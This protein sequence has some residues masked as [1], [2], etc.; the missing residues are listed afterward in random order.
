MNARDPGPA[1]HR[2]RVASRVLA[3][4]VGGY[5]LTSLIT[6]DLA[7][8]LSR[9][10]SLGPA[11]GVLAATLASF[12][13]LTVIVLGVFAARSAARAWLGL[14]TASISAAALL[15]LLRGAG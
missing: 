8:L 9:T 3:A 7:L 10:S 15:L 4:A 12:L 13:I 2:W 11:G 1:R 14:M 6:A 5:G